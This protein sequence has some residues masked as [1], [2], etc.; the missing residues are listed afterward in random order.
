M[1][2]K[3]GQDGTNGKR[4]TG[5]LYHRGISCAMFRF[6]HIVTGAYMLF[7]Y[8]KTGRSL[9]D[10]LS[11]IRGSVPDRALIIT[12]NTLEEAREFVEVNHFTAVYIDGIRMTHEQA[13]RQFEEMLAEFAAPV[14]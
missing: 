5:G 9:L 13:C 8:Y 2:R 1:G 14:K 3:I 10:Y 7:L 4:G 12:V 6:R 11:Q